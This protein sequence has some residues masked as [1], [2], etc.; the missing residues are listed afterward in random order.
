[1]PF[2]SWIKSNPVWPSER[3]TP[4]EIKSDYQSLVQQII[5]EKNRCKQIQSH[6][7]LFTMIPFPI[8]FFHQLFFLARFFVS[9]PCIGPSLKSQVAIIP[10]STKEEQREYRDVRQILILPWVEEMERGRI[11]GNTLNFPDLL[12]RDKKSN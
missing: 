11:H 8:L 5:R 2:I 1:M 10:F 3:L 9:F 4:L 6:I 12:E 7:L